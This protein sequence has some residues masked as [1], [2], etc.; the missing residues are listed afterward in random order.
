MEVLDE[1]NKPQVVGFY[2]FKISD[3]TPRLENLV[4]EEDPQDENLPQIVGFHA[5]GIENL[6]PVS[7]SIEVETGENSPQIIGFYGFEIE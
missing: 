2:G 1:S 7:F 4:I 6:K 3:I 5:I